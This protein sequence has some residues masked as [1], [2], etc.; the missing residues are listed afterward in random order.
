GVQFQ[1]YGSTGP[2][3]TETLV[4]VTTAGHQGPDDIFWNGTWTPS[5]VSLAADTNG[6]YVVAWRTFAPS[7]TETIS[8]RV[9]NANGTP[10]TGEIPVGTG[11]G[12][13][14][15][16]DGYVALGTNMPRVAMAG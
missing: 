5:L 3:G 13:T 10:R 6:D 2:V 12:G 14:T 16:H 11:T 15:T 1:P 8:A 7:G 4:N 9:F